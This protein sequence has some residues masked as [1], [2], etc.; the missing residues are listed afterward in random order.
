MSAFDRLKENAVAVGPKVISAGHAAAASAGATAYAKGG[1]AFDAALAACFMEHIVLPMKCGLAGDLV[2]LFRTNGGEFQSLV[3]IG[4][5]ARGLAKG[6]SIER[7]GPNSVGVPGA[8]HG[9]AILQAYGRLALGDLARPAIRAASEGVPWTRVARS[10]V[11]EGA[12]LLARHSP[13]N[14]YAP[15]GRIPEIGEVRRLPGLGS[16]LEAFIDM[17]EAVLESEIGDR[18]AARVQELGGFLTRE[19]FAQRPGR[20]AEAVSGSIAAGLTL[21]VPSAPT[22]GPQLIDIAR[23][24]LAREADLPSIVRAARVD[25]KARGR[26]TADGGTSVVTAADD[27]GNAVVILH[28]NSFPQFA[29]GVVLDDGL[30]LNN[31]PGRGFDLQAPPDAAN[32]PGAGKVPWTTLHAWSLAYESGETLLGATPGGVNQLPWNAQTVTELARGP[33]IAAAMTNPRWSLDAENML[34]AE[35]GVDPAIVADKRIEALSLRSAQ[36]VIHLAKNGPH[37]IAADP[38]TGATAISVY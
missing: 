3:S 33:D 32:A 17:R 7:T 12:A 34:S 24:F 23:R 5:G 26:E 10:Y 1:N 19:D 27:E 16:L 15:G 28:S 6:A 4:A 13:Y 25:A 35:D 31:R 22:H 36:Q 20:I 30:I 38:R 14:P 9:Y 21:R 11:V 29:S 37:R 8:P 2:A 18:I